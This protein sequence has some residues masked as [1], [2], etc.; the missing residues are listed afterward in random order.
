MGVVFRKETGVPF[1][2]VAKAFVRS[3]GE[4]L[5]QRAIFCIGCFE[6]TE[7]I[8]QVI[9]FFFGVAGFG[10]EEEGVEIR[11]LRRHAVGFQ[12]RGHEG[13]GERWISCFHRAGGE[14]H[15]AGVREVV[16]FGEMGEAVPWRG[17]QLPKS[18]VRKDGRI[19]VGLPGTAADGGRQEGTEEMAAAQDF[20]LERN[21]R[22]GGFLPKRFAVFLMQE[23]IHLEARQER[24]VGGRGDVHEVGALQQVIGDVAGLAGDVAVLFVE[25]GGHRESCQLLVH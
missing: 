23:R 25:L 5:G 3:I 19:V 2:E 20:F 11:F 9:S 6:V 22:H 14:E 21:G 15:L 24:V 7:E 4:E 18:G 16:V 8:H 17:G 10:E 1:A 13:G 12:I